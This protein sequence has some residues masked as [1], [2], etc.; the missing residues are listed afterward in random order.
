VCDGEHHQP[1]GHYII[2]VFDDSQEFMGQARHYHAE[3]NKDEKLGRMR[4]SNTREYVQLQ[5]ADFLAGST[6]LGPSVISRQESAT[7]VQCY[8]P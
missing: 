3:K 5:A 2:P 8:Q 4:V 6:A 1:K 7:P